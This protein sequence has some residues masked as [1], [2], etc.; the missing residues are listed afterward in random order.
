MGPT[1]IFK[2]TSETLWFPKLNGTNYHIWA[3]N[4]K[5]AL[6]AK[7]LWGI[8][9]GHELTPTCPPAVYPKLPKPSPP[10]PK[11]ASQIPK[12]T[13]STAEES[14]DKDKDKDKEKDEDKDEEETDPMI[15]MFQS[16]EYKSWETVVE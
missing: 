5:A 7:S 4:M 10:K 14:S 12:L 6:Q 16:K 11:S 8:V 15:E 9:S 2:S 3:D 13:S 1:D